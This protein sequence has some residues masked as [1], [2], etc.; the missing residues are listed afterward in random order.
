[1]L[2]LPVAVTPVI[3]PVDTASIDVIS[4][5]KSFPGEAPYNVDP[6]IL[7]ICPTQKFVPACAIA[8]TV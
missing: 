8:S 6:E 2:A 5:D 7:T 1:M 3:P 4:N